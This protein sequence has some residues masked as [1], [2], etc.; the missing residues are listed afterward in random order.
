MARGPWLSRDETRVNRRAAK[1]DQWV[2]L[3]QPGDGGVVTNTVPSRC[4]RPVPLGTTINA[5]SFKT[6]LE[7]L[8]AY[9]PYLARWRHGWLLSHR[10]P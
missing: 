9:G 3:R 7:A 4:G 8:M 5:P 2:Q 1:H 6:S 10:A